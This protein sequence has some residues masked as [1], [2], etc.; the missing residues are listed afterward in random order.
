MGIPAHMMPSC[1][2]C[3]AI[4]ERGAKVCPLCGADQTQP[5]ELPDFNSPPPRTATSVLH[6]WGVLILLISVVITSSVGIFWYNF[7][8]PRI[9]STLQSAG[10]AAKS[11]RDVREV[12]SVYF[13]R[14]ADY[15]SKLEL[16]GNRLN[17]SLQ[18]L[19]GA[20]YKLEYIPKQASLDGPCTGFV[21]HATDSIGSHI[22][23]YIDESGIVRA[24]EENRPASAQDPPF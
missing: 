22:N 23:L 2:S 4:N 1:W 13:L 9:S 16:L 18:T 12:L 10:A 20:G 17:Q 8:A 11:L 21:I 15:P 5:M 19:H 7:S 24:T 14:E 6:E 3:S